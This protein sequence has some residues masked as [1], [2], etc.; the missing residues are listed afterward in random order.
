MDS[1]ICGLCCSHWQQSR[2]TRGVANLIWNMAIGDIFQSQ[3]KSCREWDINWGTPGDI[4]QESPPIYDYLHR[5][6]VLNHS[7]SREE[8]YSAPRAGRMVFG[9]EGG[10]RTCIPT[11][12]TWCSQQST[13]AFLWLLAPI[14][15]TEFRPHHPSGQSWSAHVLPSALC[16]GRY[17]FL[18]LK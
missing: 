16:R 18:H 8:F 12:L 13:L 5:Y 7:N 1:I 4:Q 9:G 6:F 11:W 15:S 17:I 10:I 2:N 14:H 3:R